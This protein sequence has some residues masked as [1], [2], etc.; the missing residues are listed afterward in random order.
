[1]LIEFSAENFRSLKEKQTLSMLSS[2]RVSE[3]PENLTV[4]KDNF[5]LNKSSIIYGRN[6]S[7]K[8]NLLRALQVL[9][10]LVSS[11]SNFKLNDRISRYEPFKL[12]KK[13]SDKPINLE[14]DFIAKDNI[15]YHYSVS[16]TETDIIKESLLF[17]P[18]KQPTKLFIREKSKPIDFGTSLKGDRRG[19]E[20]QLLNNQLFLSKG[21]NSNIEQL[22]TPFLFFAKYFF[23][24]VFRN[25]DSD[26][27]LISSYTKFIAE[28]KDTK[29]KENLDK[30][31]R[32]ADT[33]ISSILINPVP[34]DQIKLPE[35]LPDDVKK[36]IYERYKYEIKTVHKAFEEGKTSDD[37]FFQLKDESMG[38]IKLLAV[39]GIILDAL[40][41]GTVLIID[42]LDKSLHPLLTRLLIKLFHNPKTNPN[43]AQLIFATHDISLLDKELFRRDQIW[44]T[45][46]ETDG[47]TKLYSLSDI[48]GVRKE[49]SY[50]KLYLSGRFGGTPV[51]NEL[52]F[53]SS[54]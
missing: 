35:N 22:K 53:I 43:N 45:E 23:S 13:S 6:A 8:T 16:Y 40:S 3:H 49:F 9:E 15:R 17:Y 12:D 46:K 42:E 4:T 20:K 41:D 7:G 19:V 36:Q 32:I 37:V 27:N 29:L 50:E 30:L 28:K 10:Y 1:M 52:D 21:A 5:R 47:A 18:K 26:E 38:T 25:T 24:R 44:F 2:G 39:G 48:K 54:F 14:I 33:G 11:S 31:V 34:T 51:I